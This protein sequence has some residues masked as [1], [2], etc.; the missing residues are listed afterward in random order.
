[1]T[2]PDDMGEHDPTA[3]ANDTRKRI[4]Y[5]HGRDLI[6]IRRQPRRFKNAHHEHLFAEE[7]QLRAR[8]DEVDAE[9][10]ALT[11]E[12]REL[13]QGIRDVH[14]RIRPAWSH[15]RGRRRRQVA[16]EE[17]LPPTPVKPTWVFGRDLRAI[18]LAFLSRARAALTLRQLHALLHR[19]GYA[20]DH[21]LPV[22]VLADAL[23]YEADHGRVRRVQR[24]TYTLTDAEHAPTSALPD[25]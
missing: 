15:T 13:L 20:I 25:L 12:R 8:L 6:P 3:D 1:M 4:P 21:R 2:D 17:P 19:S 18:C 14:D 9:L 10:V 24:A 11:E 16:Q 23:G 5:V 7:D 22:K